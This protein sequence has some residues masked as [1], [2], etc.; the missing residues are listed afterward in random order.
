MTYGPVKASAR[1][2]DLHA[3]DFHMIEVAGAFAGDGGY[4]Q[5]AFHTAHQQRREP[6][7][8]I[9]IEDLKAVRND[10]KSLVRNEPPVR[11]ILE[12]Y[13]WALGNQL[14]DSQ[15]LEARIDLIGP[16]WVQRPEVK[17]QFTL[18][19]EKRY[20]DPEKLIYLLNAVGLDLNDHPVCGTI[21]DRDWKFGCPLVGDE[22]K[23]YAAHMINLTFELAW[24]AKRAE[25]FMLVARKPLPDGKPANF[26]GESHFRAEAVKWDLEA[27]RECK[28]STTWQIRDDWLVKLPEYYYSS[29]D[30]LAAAAVDAL[31]EII[32]RIQSPSAGATHL[33]G[34]WLTATEAANLLVENRIYKK[35][36]SARTRVS[37]AADQKLFKTNEKT[38]RDR[39]IEFDSFSTWRWELM[40]AKGD[41][42]VDDN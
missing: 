28:A 29:L 36:P 10:L 5:P 9:L 30:N 16:M 32:S 35:L 34:R 4:V 20:P 39:R 2:L 31:D 6:T 38:G 27:L 15:T 24:R 17:R 18:R 25:R 8:S 22:Y 37:R 41:E 12:H 23:Q 7:M 3:V 26:T 11:V 19:W 14:Y 33:P 13:D 40:D 42:T 1:W 21:F